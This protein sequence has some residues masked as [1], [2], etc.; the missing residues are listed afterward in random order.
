MN[1]VPRNEA[2][3]DGLDDL[4]GVDDIYRRATALD[5]SRPSERVRDAVLSHA[6]QLAAERPSDRT[7]DTAAPA[8]STAPTASPSSAAQGR[9]WHKSPRFVPRRLST[10]VGTLAAAV[11]VG[12]LVT[13]RFLLTHDAT[14][15]S[16]PPV[17]N[18]SIA[19]PTVARQAAPPRAEDIQPYISRDQER[20]AA[21]ARARALAK[22]D[23]QIDLNA[24]S[25][26]RNAV[27]APPMQTAPAAA[28][29]PPA[30]PATLAA[31]ATPAASAPP[32]APDSSDSPASAAALRRA[33]EQGDIPKLRALFDRGVD[34]NARDADDRS[35][36]L[37]AVLNGQAKVV[38]LLLTRGANVNA[39][40]RNGTTPLQAAVSTHQ[41]AM[42]A[43][44]RAAGA[45]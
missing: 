13:P 8:L 10:V 37:L 1:D 43:S 21:T 17:E 32:A 18:A 9:R 14:L 20:A 28:P 24:V 23:A 31:P 29:V 19:P 27:F 12:L 3:S 36:L 26:Q 5:P 15:S 39:A 45:Q 22:K 16:E 11:L 44:L 33:A 7:Q 42:A 25:T 38:E 34:V 4:D 2:S 40:D 6:A 30:A 35:A 41:T